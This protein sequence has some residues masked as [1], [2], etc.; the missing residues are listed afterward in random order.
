LISVDEASRIVGRPLL[1]GELWED[2]FTEADGCWFRFSDPNLRAPVIVGAR[3]V[4]T[5]GNVIESVAKF[6]L[7]TEG[8]TRGVTA[9]GYDVFINGCENTYTRTGCAA[10]VYSEPYLAIVYV[11]FAGSGENPQFLRGLVEAVTFPMNR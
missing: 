11:G 6:Y 7:G 4:A 2:L 9:R 1:Q 5:Q 3:R 8:L 10:V